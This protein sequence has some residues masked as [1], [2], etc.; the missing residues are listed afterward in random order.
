MA[1]NPTQLTPGQAKATFAHRFG[2]RADGLRQIATRFGLRPYNVWLVWRQWTGKERGAGKPKEI[3]RIALVPNPKIEDLS[4]IALDPRNAGILPVGSIRL[5][6]ISATFSADQ[7]TGKWVPTEPSDR[8][9]ENVEFFYEVQEDGRDGHAGVRMRF[10]PMSEPYRR[11]GKID[12]Q[13]TLERINEDSDRDGNDQT[14]P[15]KGL[16]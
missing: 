7:L 14:G 4:S 11:A 5:T 16:R 9:P 2:K 1:R 3:L 13:V 15:N 12:W 6:R 8:L 10:R